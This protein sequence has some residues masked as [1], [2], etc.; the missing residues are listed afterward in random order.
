MFARKNRI[1]RREFKKINW[2]NTSTIRGVFVNINIFTSSGLKV[3]IVIPKKVIKKASRRFFW[4]RQIEACL[5]DLIRNSPA[6]GLV[7]RLH[8]E[9]ASIKELKADFFDNIN[10]HIT[11]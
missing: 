7:V 8:R 10:Y 2:K 9:P 5:Q 11:L 1:S 4:K 6:I 3:A